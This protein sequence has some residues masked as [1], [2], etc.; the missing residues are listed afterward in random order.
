MALEAMPELGLRKCTSCHV[1]KPLGAFDVGAATSIKTAY[2]CCRQCCDSQIGRRLEKGETKYTRLRARIRSLYQQARNKSSLLGSEACSEGY[3]EYEEA[4][5]AANPK[6]TTGVP[7][8]RL[9][10]CEMEEKPV[11]HGMFDTILSCLFSNIFVEVWHS[12]N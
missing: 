3:E 10:L 1:N 6:K 8:L 9:R 12:T 5:T 7:K 2:K 4:C 11:K